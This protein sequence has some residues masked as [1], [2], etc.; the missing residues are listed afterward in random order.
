MLRRE[1]P[2][3]AD[4]TPAARARAGGPAVLA[5]E[6]E[7]GFGKSTLLRAAVQRLDGFS[8]L[9]GYGE[10]SAQDDRFQLL[11]DWGAL[12]PS[13]STPRHVL[14]ATRRRP[15]SAPPCER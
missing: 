11:H 14:Q 6:G 10:E 1:P 7:A 9:R 13:T 15:S 8:V 2:G 4:D 12:P 3:E 5:I